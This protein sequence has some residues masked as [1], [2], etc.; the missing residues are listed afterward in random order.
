MHSFG[1]HITAEQI[2]KQIRSLY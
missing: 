1:G 2:K